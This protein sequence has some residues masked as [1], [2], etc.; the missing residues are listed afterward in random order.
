MATY[1]WPTVLLTNL[2]DEMNKIFDRNLMQRSDSSNVATSEWSP[3]VDV[4]E[5]KDHFEITADIPGIDPKDIHLNI[6]NGMLTIQGERKQQ[7][8]ESG[9]SYSRSERSYGVFYRRF[10]LPD[11]ADLENIKAKGKNGVLEIVIPK[12]KKHV[13]QNIEIKVEN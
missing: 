1:H 13:S 5:R 3:A 7:K 9:A 10:S 11:T 2:Q 4:I 8:E 6:E 12:S